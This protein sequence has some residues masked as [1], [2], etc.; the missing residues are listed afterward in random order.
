LKSQRQ[1]GEKRNNTRNAPEEKPSAGGSM[2]DVAS[3]AHEQKEEVNLKCLSD[4]VHS[5]RRQIWPLGRSSPT[6]WALRRDTTQ[7]N[8]KGRKHSITTVRDFTSSHY[9][10]TRPL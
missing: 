3:S 2:T 5:K 1:G 10:T 6:S 8:P 4:S 7:K 9:K